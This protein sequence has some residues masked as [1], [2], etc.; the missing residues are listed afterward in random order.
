MIIPLGKAMSS[1]SSAS[2]TT[3]NTAMFPPYTPVSLGMA[4]RPRLR[5]ASSTLASRTPREAHDRTCVLF[6]RWDS[7]HTSRHIA[8]SSARRSNLHGR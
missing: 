3:M 8:S 4:H 1:A 6:R 2:T 7:R 5:L